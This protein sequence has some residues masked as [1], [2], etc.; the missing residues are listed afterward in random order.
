MMKDVQ[1]GNTNLGLISENLNVRVISDTENVLLKN[2]S[3]EQVRQLLADNYAIVYRHYSSKSLCSSEDLEN[4]NKVS[5]SIVLHYLYMYN[6][7]RNTYRNMQ[8]F[9]L[10]FN[11][12]DFANPTTFDIIVNYYKKRYPYDWIRKCNRLLGMSAKELQKYY[13]ER[14]KF[15]NK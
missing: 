9:D 1:L 4:V 8:D 15:Y 12:K 14:E 11:D 3:I 13:E 7:W 6:N 2:Q 5:I 10:R